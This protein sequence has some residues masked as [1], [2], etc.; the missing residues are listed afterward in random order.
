VDLDTFK[1][2]IDLFDHQ[3]DYRGHNAR[4]SNQQ[5]GDKQ[6]NVRDHEKHQV[7]SNTNHPAYQMSS[8]PSTRRTLSPTKR[9]CIY[10]GDEEYEATMGGG[11]G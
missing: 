5:Q 9:R 6:R 1:L 4:I 10:E 11:Y 3:R 8:P 7:H 2:S